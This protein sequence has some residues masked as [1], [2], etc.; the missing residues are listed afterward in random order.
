MLKYPTC[1]LCGKSNATAFNY[2]GAN[3]NKISLCLQ[4][5]TEAPAIRL[6]NALVETDVLTVDG[7][8]ETENE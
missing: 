8:V 7:T 5:Q 6:M 2:V 3:G 1:A 4:C